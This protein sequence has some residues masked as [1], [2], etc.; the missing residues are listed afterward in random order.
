MKNWKIFSYVV[1]L[2]MLFMFVFSCKHD[3]NK[4]GNKNGS[5]PQINPPPKE[6]ALHIKKITLDKETKDEG[7]I[8]STI[9]FSPVSLSIA[10]LEVEAMEEGVNVTF[11]G[12]GEAKGAG[13]DWMLTSGENEIKIKLTKDAKEAQYIAKVSSRLQAGGGVYTLNGV[14]SS[15]IKGDFDKKILNGENPLFE[16]GCNHLR[17]AII[18]V[19]SEIEYKKIAVNGEDF[20]PSVGKFT[21]MSEKLF[22]LDGEEEKQ[23][24]IL[25]VPKELNKC[26]IRFERFRVRGNGKKAVIKPSITINKNGDLPKDFLENLANTEAYPLY[27]VFKGPANIAI[28]ISEYERAYKVKT[29]KIND[30]E[31][32]MTEKQRIVEKEID[33]NATTP[34]LVKVEFVPKDEATVQPLI[35]NFKL[36]EGGEK[37]CV[38]GVRVVG[39]NDVGMV[40]GAGVLPESF[41]KHT[42]DNSN[43][44]Y[45][46][47]GK[48]A[49][50]VLYVEDEE[51]VEKAKFKLDG[52]EDGEEDITSSN[53]D[54]FIIHT[55]DIKDEVEHQ[56][57]IEVLPKDEDL[58][59]PLKMKF[60]LQ[61]SGEKMLIQSEGLEF[62]INGVMS[63]SMP[64][65]VKEHLLD[66]TSPLYELDGEIVSVEIETE[67]ELV[68]EKIKNIVFSFE[69]E[70]AKTL[71][72]EARNNGFG[73]FWTLKTSFI[74]KEVEKAYNL[75]IDVIPTDDEVYKG[76]SYSLK[77]KNT[78]A[79][80]EMPLLFILDNEAYKTGAQITAKGSDAVI[81]V[82]ASYD[83]MKSVNI[84][85][86]G[87]GALDCEIKEESDG[88]GGSIYYAERKIELVKEDETPEYKVTI[89]VVPKNEARYKPATCEWKVMGTKLD[90]S[91]AKFAVDHNG[92]QRIEPYIVFKDGVEGKSLDD[93][94]STH[95][96]F[97]A[98]TESPKAEVRYALL[99]LKDKMIDFIDAPTTEKY[100]VMQNSNGE[101]T[102]EKITLFGD[103]PTRIKV[104]VVAEDGSEDEEDG[105]YTLD[106]N[107][108]AL[109]FSYDAK[110]QDARFADFE[111]KGYGEVVLKKSSIKDDGNVYFAFRV[112]DEDKG[113]FK[114]GDSLAEGQSPF[115]KLPQT[116]KEKKASFQTYTSVLNASKLKNGQATEL[117]LKCNMKEVESDADAFT[118][119][120]KVK[121]ED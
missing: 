63:S 113:G 79:I 13:W 85:V 91:N 34:T 2:F 7:A 21:K 36:Q 106:L 5:N 102:S 119:I 59:I 48:T 116:E 110:L 72:M 71:E 80:V 75:K 64:K 68:S 93:Y 47:A 23:F 54:T 87:M 70:Q 15:D 96:T 37:P 6:P 10:H 100:K 39:V 29:I 3:G 46:F 18:T 45:K 104:W 12:L 73:N 56:I 32:A 101:H 95:I 77:V 8:S 103:K 92:E 67:E 1:C 41:A 27:Y 74:M 97:T 26:A 66:G 81:A 83:I 99:G 86:E 78:G 107:P 120:V 38:F 98:F 108:M 115:V 33:I 42:V 76:F 19:P 65:E 88:K 16:A 114:V 17:L 22:M 69:G 82:G 31:D 14:Y 118:F 44:L 35:W 94:G 111:N 105:L 24:S 20:P 50:V 62:S 84:N 58:N 51:I 11:E 89:K 117:E 43:P 9:N 30:V 55:C 25:M 57:D 40:P 52:N 60:R 121:V 4:D 112:W 53:G 90:K 28:N 109:R 49:R 61:R